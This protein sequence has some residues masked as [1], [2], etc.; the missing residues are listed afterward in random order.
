[1]RE[2]TFLELKEQ[3]KDLKLEDYEEYLKLVSIPEPNK[4]VQSEL[5]FVNFVKN[6]LII[7]LSEE[8]S[9]GIG[10]KLWEK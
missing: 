9:A 4:D 2:E 6:T 3:T 8:V 5:E 7:Y 10:F 1:M